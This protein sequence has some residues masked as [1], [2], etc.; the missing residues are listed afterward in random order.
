MGCWK[1]AADGAYVVISNTNSKRQ[2][3][4]TPRLLI[5]DTAPLSLLFSLPSSLQAA[6]DPAAA[7]DPAIALTAQRS[8][9]AAGAGSGW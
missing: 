9:P 3:L 8:R 7:H 5:T 4:V 6:G 2:R 1:A